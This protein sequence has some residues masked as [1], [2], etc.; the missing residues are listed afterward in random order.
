M[1]PDSEKILK[2]IASMMRVIFAL[3]LRET[4]TRYG[5]LKIGY[6]WAFLEPMLFI[7]ML[8]AIFT[9]VRNLNSSTMPQILFYVTGI[10]PFFL[11]RNVM[12]QTMYAVRAN[13]QLLTFPQVHAFDLMIARALL[14]LATFIVVITVLVSVIGVTGINPVDVEDYLGLYQAVFL[15]SLLGMAGGFTASALIPMFPSVQI[16]ITGVLIRPLFF[17]SG[18]FFTADVIPE[19]FRAYALLNPLLQLIELF[20]SS[21]FHEYESQHV[22]LKYIYGSV[23]CILFFGLLIQ[24]A[25]RRFSMRIA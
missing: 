13:Y 4:K 2:A 17:I 9:Y 23:L 15:I 3:M 11:F 8:S 20:R 22:D 16:I 1:G 7:T 10:M 24:R 18:V 5:R 14:E 19:K 6:L 12:I 25:L 21:F